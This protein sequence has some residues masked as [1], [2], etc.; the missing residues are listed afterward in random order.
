MMEAAAIARNAM[1]ARL[2]AA[3]PRLAAR[4]AR[5]RLSTLLLVV[6]IGA[7]LLAWR[8]DHLEQ[9]AEI[10][11]LQNPNPSWSVDQVLGAP[12]T[13]TFGDISSA[14]ASQTPDGQPEW[15]LLEFDEVTPVAVHVYETHNPGAVVKIARVNLFGG[16]SV[17]WEG[18]DPTAPPLP[19]GVSKFPAGGAPATTRI[20]IYLDSPAFPGWNEIDAVAL[21]DSQGKP[22]WAKRAAAS[23][24]YGASGSLQAAW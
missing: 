16:E 21:I 20:K 6:T 18:T 1:L 23:S 2:A 9:A 8:R 13:T 22:H 17:L 24:S 4:A 10:A 12:N 11:R 7:V 14:W 3:F 15:L 19:G 5:F